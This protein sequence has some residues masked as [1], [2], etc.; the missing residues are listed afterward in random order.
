MHFKISLIKVN[1]K[2][3]SIWA[4]GEMGGGGGQPLPLCGKSEKG[5][6][7]WEIKIKKGRKRNEKISIENAEYVCK[8]REK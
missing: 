3:C 6:R 5:K 1:Q 2:Y 4:G 8:K 7:N